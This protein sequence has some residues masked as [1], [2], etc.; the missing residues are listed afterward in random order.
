MP[1]ILILKYSIQYGIISSVLP[2]R[3]QILGAK[4]KPNTEITMP[5]TVIEYTIKEKVLE[6]PVLS[7][8][9]KRLVTNAFPPDPNINPIADTK[10]KKGITRLMD[11]KGVL[12]T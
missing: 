10:T 2:N 5:T 4:I 1:T 3:T 7:P 8:F 6:A 11:A 12:P 9:P